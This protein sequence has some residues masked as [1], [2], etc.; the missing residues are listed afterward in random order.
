MTTIVWD[1]RTLAADT[2]ATA[3]GLR[4][5]RNVKIWRHGQALVGACGDQAACHKFRQWVIDGMA[6]NNPFHDADGN[7][8]V[9]TKDRALCFGTHGAWVV[10]E[11][12]YSLGSG[13]QIA[14]GALA[15]G[16]TA[17]KAVEIAARYDTMT[18]G[19][20]TELHL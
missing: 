18:G 16:A 6:G 14:L 13:Y 10:S 9:V 19:D 17:R 2:L 20:I 4:D 3:N 5:N 1:G 7:G 11:P 12:F 15:M 8:I